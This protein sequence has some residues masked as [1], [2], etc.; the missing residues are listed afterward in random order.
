[1]ARTRAGG[2][3]VPGPTSL[4]LFL[5]RGRLWRAGTKP[6]AARRTDPHL[7]GSRLRRA[8]FLPGRDDPDDRSGADDGS[9]DL[10]VFAYAGSP[11]D[12]V[13]VGLSGCA[14]VT[15]GHISRTAALT[16]GPA[17][18]DRLANLVGWPSSVVYACLRSTDQDERLSP[19]HR[20]A[21][22]R[23]RSL[24]ARVRL[25]RCRPRS[26]VSGRRSDRL[27]AP[28][29]KPILIELLVSVPL[30]FDPPHTDD[31]PDPRRR[32]AA[33]AGNAGGGPALPAE[34]S[35]RRWTL[36]A[37]CATTFMLLLDIT[38]VVVA[39][40]SIQRRF[41]AGLSG[42]QWTLDAYALTLA[43]LI[44]TCGALADRYGRRLVFRA[45]WASSARPPFCAGSRG[46]SR[47]RSRASTPGGRGRRAVRDR[48][49]ADR[50]GVSGCRARPGASG[51]GRDRR[52]RRRN[53]ALNRRHD[54]RFGRVALDVLRQ[55]PGRGRRAVSRAQ[56]DVGI[57]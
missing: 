23:V 27:T 25:F 57:P 29:R 10:A 8:P 41:A 21:H 16:P 47:A 48:A 34:D 40:P 31:R 12:I 11:D 1:M 17:L 46:T 52:C 2:L 33:L 35:R 4:L 30:P 50:S 36:V 53:R 39:L 56:T 43:V 54:H 24:P 13:T 42:L 14:T 26:F 28:S 9:A 15:N 20:L 18:L 22:A 51:L 32:I 7:A 5:L 3:V 49:G 38:I 6:A 55:R 19:K 37:V 45:A 44:L